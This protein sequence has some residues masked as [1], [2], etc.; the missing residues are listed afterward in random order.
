MIEDNMISFVKKDKINIL[1][2][3]E[4]YRG[5]ILAIFCLQALAFNMVTSA[6]LS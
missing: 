5:G 2:M 1:N 6:C 3:L 4:G